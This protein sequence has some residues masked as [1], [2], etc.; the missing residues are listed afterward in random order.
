MKPNALKPAA[1]TP[2]KEVTTPGS[3]ADPPPHYEEWDDATRAAPHLTVDQ[4]P[5]RPA[6][7]IVVS[8]DVAKKSVERVSSGH[9]SELLD[10][11]KELHANASSLREDVGRRAPD[12]D[13]VTRLEQRIE[14]TEA[15][16]YRLDDLVAVTRQQRDVAVSDLSRIV[17]RVAGQVA[18]EQ[19]DDPALAERYRR[20][21]AYVALRGADIAEGIDRARRERELVAKAKADAAK[22]AS[23]KLADHKG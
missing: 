19:E 3:C 5:P 20:S 10:A 11:S 1:A 2:E 18:K 4:L 6:G 9:R 16:L 15:S 7:V 23:D 13:E 12:L 17:R 14:E 21:L 8:G 22:A